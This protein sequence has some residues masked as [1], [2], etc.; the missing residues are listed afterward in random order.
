MEYL[1]AAILEADVAIA[2]LLLVFVGLVYK[3]GEEFSSRSGDR[4]KNVA[5][6]GMLPLGLSLWCAWVCVSYL[7]GGDARLLRT[8]IIMFRTDLIST[9]LYAS[10]VLF[11]YL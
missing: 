5:R 7:S 9:A 4:V 2:G 8:I 10:I 3:R 1:V 6:L 11:V